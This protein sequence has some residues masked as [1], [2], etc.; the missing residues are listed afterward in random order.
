M[1]RKLS[2]L[3]ANMFQLALKLYDFSMRKPQIIQV[4][5]AS[6]LAG[7]TSM[8]IALACCG[9]VPRKSVVVFGDQTNIIVWNPAKHMEHFVRKAHFQSVAADFGFIAP[10]P[11]IPQLELA[12]TEAFA[13]LE[14]LKP[15]PPTAPYASAKSAAPRTK[16]VVVQEKNLGDY[17]A[18]TLL[19][20][21][22]AGLAQYLSDNGYAA[23]K[24]V[25]SWTEYYIAKGWYLTAFKIHRDVDA[26][27]LALATESIRMSF[28]T[29]V[30][31]NPY[32]VPASNRGLGTLRIFFVSDGIYEGRVGDKPWQE[33]KWHAD[34]LSVAPTL[35]KHLGLEV[36]AMPS[37][38]QV[39]AFTDDDWTGSPKSSDITFV[40]APN[41]PSSANDPSW[42]MIAFGAIGVGVGGLILV[43]IF[44]NSQ[45]G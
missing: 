35:A 26:E 41:S 45:K 34:A 20:S 24:D 22:S 5:C 27:E 40:P 31:V 16:P 39:T 14:R 1:N 42:P 36:S 12:S 4:R 19:A 11:S 6:V 33:S 29:D 28:K 30:P 37:T 25:T 15:P 23:G 3:H 17:H 32:R 43:R 10:T 44:A 7:M 13:D 9:V 8:T 38:P 21:D 2:L 18:V